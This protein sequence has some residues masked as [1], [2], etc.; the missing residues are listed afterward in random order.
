MSP[1][2]H[3]TP[4]ELEVKNKIENSPRRNPGG[5][6]A[7]D[8]IEAGLLPQTKLARQFKCGNSL[9]KDLCQ[10]LG[11][12]RNLKRGIIPKSAGQKGRRETSLGSIT[13]DKKRQ[14]KL[15]AAAKG[16]D[17]VAEGAL[18]REFGIRIVAVEEYEAKEK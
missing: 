5:L 11:V 15:L 2:M 8:W 1:L 4:R 14:V 6:S 7:K 13:A 12:Q 18:L 9:M 17:E 10:K 3:L 16:G